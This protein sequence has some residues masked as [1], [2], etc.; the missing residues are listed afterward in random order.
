MNLPHLF[1]GEE[2]VAFWNR[3]REKHFYFHRPAM[4]EEGRIPSFLYSSEVPPRMEGWEWWGS[5]G[6]SCGSASGDTAWVTGKGRCVESFAS[7]CLCW[8][9]TERAEWNSLR[10]TVLCL[11]WVLPGYWG[12]KSEKGWVRDS[13]KAHGWCPCCVNGAHCQHQDQAL[14]WHFSCAMHTMLFLLT[15]GHC[16]P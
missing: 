9:W 10:M 4:G 5:G 16:I 6:A 12:V 7:G 1:H 11:E 8:G 13:P 15:D 14:R 3:S 2:N